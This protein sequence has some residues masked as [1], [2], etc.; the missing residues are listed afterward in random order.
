MLYGIVQGGRFKSLR[1]KSAQA[2]GAMAFDGMAI[3]GSFGKDEMVATLTSIIPH[4]PEEK[5]RHLL[6]IGRIEDIFNAVELGVDTFD[7]VI[8]TREARHGRIWTTAGAYDIRKGINKNRHTRLERSC[9]CPACSNG[10]T[11]AKLHELFKI[12]NPAAGRYA[13]LHNVWF[14]NTLMERIRRALQR[15]TYRHLKKAFMK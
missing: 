11:K 2:I 8:P 5:P 15:G 14:F 13:T 7:C 3:G 4:L 12:K 9:G 1:I 6:G 10:M